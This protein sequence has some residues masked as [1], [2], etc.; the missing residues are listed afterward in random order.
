MIRIASSLVRLV[1]LLHQWALLFEYLLACI[2]MDGDLLEPLVE[3]FPVLDLDVIDRVG[4][5]DAYALHFTNESD[6]A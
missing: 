5:V 3:R 2:P 6:Y 1:E 4:F